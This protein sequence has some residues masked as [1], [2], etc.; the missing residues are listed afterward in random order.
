MNKVL[1]GWPLLWCRSLLTQ[2]GICLTLDP[3]FKFLEVA[4]PYIARRLLTDEDPAL[5][6]RL[7]QV[8]SASPR[9]HSILSAP[10]NELCRTAAGKKQIILHLYA[11]CKAQGETGGPTCYCCLKYCFKREERHKS[12]WRGAAK[13]FKGLHFCPS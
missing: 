12:S 4:Y 13:W 5:R 6:E 2:E 3:T 8:H 9:S 7:F 10:I 11:T 1:T